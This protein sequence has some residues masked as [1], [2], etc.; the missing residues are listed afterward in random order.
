MI[1]K[2]IHTHLD[3]RLDIQETAAGEVEKIVSGINVVAILKD[4]QMELALAAQEALRICEKSA[5]DAA[6][7]GVR[8]AR[9]VRQRIEDEKTI[10]FE[11]SKD[12]SLNKESADAR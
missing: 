2:V 11:K 8:F 3:N 4:P 10:I 6:T 7:E 9:D 5:Q 12:P 1:D